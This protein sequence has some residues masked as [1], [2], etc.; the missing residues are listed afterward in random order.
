MKGPA[1][2]RWPRDGH[3]TR[4]PCVRVSVTTHCWGLAGSKTT[5]CS[6]DA[7]SNF[8]TGHQMNPSCSEEHTL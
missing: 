1:Q 8:L 2:P 3:E 4:L 7:P 6:I 5:H